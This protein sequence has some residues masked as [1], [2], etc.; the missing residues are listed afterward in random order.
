MTDRSIES[1]ATA[2]IYL[3]AGIGCGLALDITA[4]WLLTDYSLVQFVFLRSAFGLMFF[5]L[6]AKPMGGLRQLTSKRW[7]WHVMRALMACGAMFG[8]F[9]ALSHIPLV[10][11]LTIAFTAPLMVTAMSAWFLR[12]PIGWRRWLAVLIGF[13]GVLIVLRPGTGL[14]HPSALGVIAAALFYAGL[15]ITSRK[16]ADTENSYSLSVYAIVG[17]FL[18]SSLLV[19]DHWQMPAT[20]DWALFLFAGLCSAGAWVGIVGGYRRASPALLAPLEYLALIGGAIAG[21]LIWDEIP[22][23]WVVVGG[24]VIIGSGLFVVYRDVS[25]A[26]SGRL[27]RAFSVGNTAPAKRERE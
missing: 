17:P 11:V 9:N 2:V 1:N 12:E 10:S 18:I 14:L 6:I 24:L 5:L 19:R 23:R 27:L 3:L 26:L 16:L 15:A 25:S 4:K 21:F 8:F 22:D 20:T 7:R 13:A